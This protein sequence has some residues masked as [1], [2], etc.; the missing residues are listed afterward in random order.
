[1][2]L[3][4]QQYEPKI[5][6][7]TEKINA[8]NLRIDQVGLQ[9][10]ADDPSIVAGAAN[11]GGTATKTDTKKKAAPASGTTGAT[12]A[13]EI[14]TYNA[15]LKVL[16]D[17]MTV[18]MNNI[19]ETKTSTFAFFFN[20]KLAEQVAPGNYIPVP[21]LSV[22]AGT[23]IPA[24]QSYTAT[25]GPDATDNFG[26]MMTPGGTYDVVVLSI[27]NQDLPD[28]VMYKNT[29]TGSQK[30]PQPLVQFQYVDETTIIPAN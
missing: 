29:W 3:I 13:D 12:M 9:G 24:T 7:I 8:A 21:A 10:P 20:L 19:Q 28:Y 1:M 18:A 5:A 27:Y 16:T 2:Q 17:A 4:A 30:F 23:T 26:N 15:E 25:F 22:A 11:T 14:A 6:A